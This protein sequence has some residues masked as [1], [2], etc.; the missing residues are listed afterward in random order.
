MPPGRTLG[1]PQ[2]APKTP[3]REGGHWNG[4]PA[5][6][7][8]GFM[9]P[10]APKWVPDDLLKKSAL[11]T[12]RQPKVMKKNFQPTSPYP[13]LPATCTCSLSSQGPKSWNLGVKYLNLG[14]KLSHNHNIPKCSPMH[15][16]HVGILWLCDNFPLKLRYLTPK[17]QLLGPCEDRE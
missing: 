16:A 3:S 10:I 11:K 8:F 9:V 1:S 17:F 7:I 6:W 14:G 2:K 15:K 4:G 12:H 5:G 13:T